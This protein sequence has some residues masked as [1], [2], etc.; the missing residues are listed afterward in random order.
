LSEAERGA[1]AARVPAFVGGAYGIAAAA[2]SSAESISGPAW[3]SRIFANGARR[4]AEARLRGFDYALLAAI[5]LLGGIE[6]PHV[7]DLH[8]QHCHA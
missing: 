7:S 8:H 2:L 1:R 5:T 3:L 4:R 6:H